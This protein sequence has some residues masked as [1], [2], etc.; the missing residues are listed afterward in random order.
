MTL[1]TYI[2]NKREQLINLDLLV[3]IPEI[4]LASISFN[5][6]LFLFW[7]VGV[8]SVHALDYAA[9]VHQRTV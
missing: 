3:E 8:G 5:S 7:A 4:S 1:K 9:F 2:M 6:F